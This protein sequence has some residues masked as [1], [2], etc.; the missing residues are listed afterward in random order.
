MHHR[1]RQARLRGLHGGAGLLQLGLGLRQLGAALAHGLRLG[2][3]TVALGARHR[4]GA[5]R[6]VQP[7]LADE[8]AGHQLLGAGQF[9]LG[10]AQRGVGLGELRLRL[11]APGAAQ[12]RQACLHLL[13]VGLGLGQRGLGFVGL[14]AQQHVALA[15]GI[16]L[17]HGHVGHAAGERGT[18]AD[19]RGGGHAGRK[20]QG[21]HQRGGAERHHIHLRRP[22]PP[23]GRRC[24]HDEQHHQ[25]PQGGPPALHATH[26]G[27]R[28]MQ[29]E[30]DKP[31]EPDMRRIIRIC[32]PH[33]SSA[34]ETHPC[35]SP[36]G[37]PKPSPSPP[38]W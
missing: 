22:Q 34:A 37:P 12:A 10:G 1:L 33:P 27:A 26:L 6:V 13:G 19:A 25:S 28:G 3:G 38:N 14:Q 32:L 18:H 24:P 11:G 16:A 36:T 23:C 5:A 29:W 17:A 8:A 20:L 2:A 7:R 31:R 15:H 35:A 30:Q 4:H 9:T 21:A